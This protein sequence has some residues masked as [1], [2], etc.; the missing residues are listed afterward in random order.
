MAIGD[1]ISATDYNSIRTKIQNVMAI[2]T[3]NLGYGQT[4]FSSLVSA[5]NSVT[6]AQWDA[7]RYDIYN[8]V[9]HQT[10]SPP[11]IATVVVGDVIQQRLS[12]DIC[13]VGYFNE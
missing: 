9:L 1:F 12:V 8:A 13:M 7:L 2:G 6:K 5:G 10:G 4:T 11:S 3:G